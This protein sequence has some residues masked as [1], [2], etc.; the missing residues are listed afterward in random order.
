[1][2][3]ECAGAATTLAQS[4]NIARPGGR[5]L[6]FG[7]YT[8]EQAELPFYQ[9]YYKELTVINSRAATRENYQTCIDLV[10][11]GQVEL[12]SMI[13]HVLPLADL[14]KAITLLNERDDHRMKIILDHA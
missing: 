6:L 5:I 13:S 9:L 1:L 14:E 4:I 3:I 12:D 10:S 7:I 11:S 2:V 8:F